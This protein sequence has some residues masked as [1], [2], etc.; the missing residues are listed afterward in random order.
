M[1]RALRT[2]I[3]MAVIAATAAGCT[4]GGGAEKPSVLGKSCDRPS[5]TWLNVSQR[6]VVTDLRNRRYTKG[7]QV[8][9]KK[10]TEFARY[11]V[12]VR[13]EGPGVPAEEVLRSLE[14]HLGPAGGLAL[15]AEKPGAVTQDD[16]GGY[17]ARPAEKTG[18]YVTARAIDLVDADFRYTCANSSP[19]GLGH[20]VSWQSAEEIMVTCGAAPRA[21]RDEAEAE[22]AR[23]G[24]R[25]GDPA[26]A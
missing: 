11:R 3:A 14:R 16:P 5:Y 12:S 8:S 2:A 4:S 17:A 21:G 19:A 22:A 20:A 18:N 15:G 26:V 9:T 6:P 23:L 13:A 24:C 10:L 1:K 25:K 7:Q